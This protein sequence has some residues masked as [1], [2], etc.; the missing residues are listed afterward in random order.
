MISLSQWCE[1]NQKPQLLALYDTAANPLPPSRVPFSSGKEYHFRCPVCNI[2]WTEKCNKLNRRKKGSYNVIKQRPEETF[3]PYCKG[4][5]PSPYYN[6]ATAVPWVSSW[7]DRA[8]N[9]HKPEEFLPS[10]HKKF[11]LKCQKCGYSFPQPVRISEQSTPLLCPCCEGGKNR[12]VTQSNCLATLYSDISEELDIGRNGGITGKMILPSYNKD[13]WFICPLGHRYQARVSNRTYLKRGC[14]ICN[15][16]RKTSFP[17][18]AIR[19]YLQK[20]APDLQSRQDDPYTGRNIDI[21]LPGK[22][23]A[24]E[25]SSLYYHG[26]NRTKADAAKI[27]LL[28]QY[29]RVYIIAEKG[30][31]PFPE[32]HPLVKTISA[33]VFALTRKICAQ[34]DQLIY[35]LMQRLFPEQG[36]YPHVNIMRD[37]LLI[38]QQYI[39][40]PVDHSFEDKF[41]TLAA[42]WATGLNGSLTPSMFRPTS[43]YKFFWNCRSCKG[44]Y[45]M[46]M[47]NRTK[48]NPDT[49]PYCC[50]KSQYKSPLLIET[51]PIVKAFWST[52]LN[53]IPLS[54]VAVASEKSYIFELM[55]G[56]IIP[57]RICNLSAWLRNH[58]DRNIE[59]YLEQQWKK[60][61]K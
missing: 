21:L 60:Y 36:S 17:E 26:K 2:H 59:Q 9:S 54:Q 19:F 7:W 48:V 42:D 44:V 56:R 31:K 5:R 49:C 3:C 41:P 11:Y 38:L 51:Y 43:P 35:E 37:Q 10:T 27:R 30:Y 40:T 4:E 46:S 61:L 13:L 14:P 45:Q 20:C 12:E 28:A 53:D 47:A 55:D 29:Y 33:P 16:R 24:I 1:Q 25:F 39:N 18:Q 23:T 57:I 50:H 8:R 15:E 6:L 52:V 22:K 34:Y 32:P 58:S